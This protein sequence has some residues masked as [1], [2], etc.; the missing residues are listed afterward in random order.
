MPCS[1][2][3]FKRT[4]GSV[5]DEKK[6]LSKGRNIRGKWRSP[7]R[8]VDEEVE[9]EKNWW[10][11]TVVGGYSHQWLDQQNTVWVVPDSALFL[12][13]TEEWHKER[14]VTSSITEMAMCK[15]YQGII[16]MGEK[17]IPLILRQLENEGGHPDH[18]FWAL[19]A[20]TKTNP[21]PEELWGN[22]PAMA[23]AWLDWAVNNNK[24][25]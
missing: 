11:R 25:Y 9:N 10:E 19:E 5:S 22:M 8:K 18:W 14:G 21:V 16:A 15:S 2:I 7:D 20:L 13:L 12:S 6:Q 4:E 1:L 23:K 17:V 24:F 3:E